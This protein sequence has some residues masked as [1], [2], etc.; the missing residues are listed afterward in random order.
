MAKGGFLNKKNKGKETMVGTKCSRR[1][2]FPW[3]FF[4]LSFAY[5]NLKFL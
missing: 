3:G 2:L 5:Y 1:K 4:S